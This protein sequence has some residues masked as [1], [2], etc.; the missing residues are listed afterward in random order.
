M[1]KS[2]LD[3]LLV[4]AQ[5][6]RDTVRSDLDNEDFAPVERDFVCKFIQ[7]TNP[8]PV[9]T[10][11]FGKHRAIPGTAE[12]EFKIVTYLSDNGTSAPMFEPYLLSCGFKVAIDGGVRTYTPSSVD[13]DWTW[14]TAMKYTGVATTGES[15][16]TTL[17]HI[18]CDG[19][20]E[21]TLGEQI[22]LTCTGKGVVLAAPVLGDYVTGTLALPE[23][24][25]PVMI[26]ASTMQAMGIS[27]D[28]IKFSVAFG[29]EVTLKKAPT[30]DFQFGFCYA[31]IT[32]RNYQI[33][34]TVYQDANTPYTVLTVGTLGT[35]DIAVGASGAKVRVSCPLDYFQIT[36]VQP[37]TDAGQNT[38]EITGTIEFEDLEIKTGE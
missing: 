1:S 35:F 3:V 34:L 4:G 24:T 32:D 5:A 16:I 21:G 13:T 19:I 30:T 18:L 15:E 25:V 17:N 12:G 11:H 38:W 28:I 14:F 7:T 36:D 37:G 33:K 22:K 6:D 29:N 27:W 9:I 31:D 23:D 10:P 2:E 26:K 8:L 20:I